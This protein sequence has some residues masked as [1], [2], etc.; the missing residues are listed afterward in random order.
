M[1]DTPQPHIRIKIREEGPMVNAWLVIPGHEESAFR[2]GSIAKVV[3]QADAQA[4]AD[5][6]SLIKR[7]LT[8]ILKAEDMPEPTGFYTEPAKD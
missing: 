4:E 1:T 5:F 2:I 6:H 3:F 8:A 7:T